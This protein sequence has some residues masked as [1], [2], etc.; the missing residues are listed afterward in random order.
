MNRKIKLLLGGFILLFAAT[1][2]SDT[3]EPSAI[4]GEPL[5]LS[6]SEKQ[7]A[8]SSSEFAL[9]LFKV[10]NQGREEQNTLVSPY[11]AM[12]VLAMVA[13]GADGTTRQE[14]V[15]ALMMGDNVDEINSYI[16]HLRSGLAKADPNS[17]LLSA[18]S[19]WLNKGYEALEQFRQNCATYY[20][21]SCKSIDFSSSKATDAI[22]KWVSDGTKGMI[23]SMFSSLDPGAKLYALNATYFHGMWT[24]PFGEKRMHAFYNLDRKRERVVFMF[25]DFYFQHYDDTTGVSLLKLPYGNQCYEMDILIPNDKININ[26]CIKSLTLDQINEMLAGASASIG[27]TYNVGLPKF[28]VAFDYDM[29]DVFKAM[30]IKSAFSESPN[31][32]NLVKGGGALPLTGSRQS[33]IIDVDEKGTEAASVTSVK[34]GYTATITTHQFI[35]DSPFVYIIRECNSGAILFIG[36][37]VSIKQTQQ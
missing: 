25:E 28:K 15:D 32:N 3:S 27:I 16:E 22:N 33:S 17:E 12:Q 8:A 26:D 2:C 31:F 30:G 14:I 5:Q 6:P 13:N 19:I 20:G 37:M 11:S 24:H 1:A 34:D 23:P 35:V 4:Q 36:K 7:M 18:N 10:L 9:S 29:I 21:A